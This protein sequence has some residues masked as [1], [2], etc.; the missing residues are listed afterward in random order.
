MHV[1]WS[2]LEARNACPIH[3][4]LPAAQSSS[5]D[6]CILCSTRYYNCPPISEMAADLRHLLSGKAGGL[7]KKKCVIVR[8]LCVIASKTTWGVVL[9]V[10]CFCPVRVIPPTHTLLVSVCSLPLLCSL[11]EDWGEPVSPRD[12]GLLRDAAAVYEQG[13]QCCTEVTGSW[14]GSVEQNWHHTL[15]NLLIF[16]MLMIQLTWVH[17]DFV[18]WVQR[19]HTFKG[20]DVCFYIVLVNK[21]SEK[22]KTNMSALT[23]LHCL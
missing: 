11:S 4:T 15:H 1:Y 18:L 6:I 7:K 8:P 13:E 3:F 17:N 19:I 22:I 5:Y 12:E 14:R 2:H 16:W 21:S 20:W 10:Y 9:C 23:S